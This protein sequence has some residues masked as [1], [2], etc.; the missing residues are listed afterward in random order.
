MWI[1]CQ[2]ISRI[3]Y[4]IYVQYLSLLLDLSQC[5]THHWVKKKP[6]QELGKQHRNRRGFFLNV[7]FIYISDIYS[8]IQLHLHLVCNIFSPSKTSFL[9]Q[10]SE[11]KPTATLGNSFENNPPVASFFSGIEIVTS[12]I[13]NNAYN[14]NR[15]LS[16]ETE[17]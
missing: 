2:K 12:L 16:K 8:I 13:I 17:V 11:K 1:H 14:F 9:P 15:W 5:N 3:K 7:Y 6:N 10:I 4:W